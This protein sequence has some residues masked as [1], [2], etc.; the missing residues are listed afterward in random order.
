[1]IYP[2]H[3][4]IKLNDHIAI[5]N[6]N[7]TD[8][9]ELKVIKLLEPIQ[10]LLESYPRNSIYIYKSGGLFHSEALLQVGE[11]YASANS[12]SCTLEDSISKLVPKLIESTN[13]KN[14]FPR[15]KQLA[16]GDSYETTA[17]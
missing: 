9:E 15:N 1:V 17:K 5:F 14:L 8:V 7:A 16:M 13:T 3:S 4:F 10:E 11:K 12:V 2:Q 6:I